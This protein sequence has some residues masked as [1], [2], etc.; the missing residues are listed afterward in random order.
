MSWLERWFGQRAGEEKPARSVFGKARWAGPGSAAGSVERAARGPFICLRGTGTSR[1]PTFEPLF[2]TGDGHLLLVA[3]SRSGKARDVNIWSLL[4]NGDSAV[5]MDTKGE[6]AAVTARARRE[7]GHEVYCLNPFKLHAGPPWNLPSHGFNP[8]VAMDPKS[9]NFTSDVESLNG[10]LVQH[11]SNEAAHWAEGGRSLVGGI[12]VYLIAR[13]RERGE[14]ASLGRLREYL[15]MGDKDFEGCV[16]EMI[17]AGGLAA[18][19]LAM[20][21]NLT[22]ELRSFKS[23]AKTQTTWLSDPVMVDVTRRHDF[24]FADLK[25]KKM[26]VYVILPS[27][28]ISKGMTYNRY[29]RLILQS[30]LDAMTATPKQS[31]RPVWFLI[32]EFYSLG[33]M[34]VVERMM[35]EGAGYGIQLQPIVQNLGQLKELYR[36]NWETFIANAAVQQ[37]FAPRDMTTADYVSKMLGQFTAN[38][39]T[40]GA[41][42]RVSVSET[43]RPLLRPE[44]VMQLTEHE[45]IVFLKGCPYPLRLYRSPYF[46]E[47]WGLQGRFDQNPYF[48]G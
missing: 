5:V 2:Y 25:R 34:P 43:G 24:S 26:T 40:I 32:D 1:N 48:V 13:A 21:G 42:G 31:S 36:S 6:L 46:K 30:A 10:A 3:P 41:D 38:P 39:H 7:M 15:T 9:A 28:L 8:L 37:W 16:A 22:N 14:V 17:R 35:S 19:R 4:E 45:Q 33:T 29:L 11:D 18:D 44:E 27:R 12:V 47:E 23:T 20:F